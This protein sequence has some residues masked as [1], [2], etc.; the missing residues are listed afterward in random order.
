MRGNVIPGATGA[1]FTVAEADAS[2]AEPHNRRQSLRMVLEI[3]L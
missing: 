3:M 2:T 1:A